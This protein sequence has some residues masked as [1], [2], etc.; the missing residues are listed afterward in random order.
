M[1]DI[2]LIIASICVLILLW[3]MLYDSNRFVVVKH[4]FTGSKLKKKARFVLL[5]DLHNKRF[6]KNNEALVAAIRECEPDFIAVAGDMLTAKPKADTGNAVE[7]IRRLAAEYPIYYGSGNHEQRLKLYPEVY[8]DMHERYESAIAETGAVRLINDHVTLPEYGISI[9][10]AEIDSCYYK[11]FYT[12]EMEPGYMEHILGQADRENY[13]LLLAHNPDYFPQYAAW[14]ADLVCSGHVHGGIVRVPFWGKGIASPS[15]SFF[16]KYDGGVFRELK[17][18]M[19]LSRGL[20]IHTIPFRVFNPAEL[21]VVE[22]HP[23]KQEE[24]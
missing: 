4:T 23:E 11:R 5:A 22:L 10:A 2:I 17:S 16:P 1:F 20:G 15:V 19:L 14:K 24:M 12:R 21:I 18:I 7:L 13:T 9:Y 3:V 8:G 6:G